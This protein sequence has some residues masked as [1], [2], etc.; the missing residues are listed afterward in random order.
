MS[1]SNVTVDFIFLGVQGP[2]LPAGTVPWLKVLSHGVELIKTSLEVG[3]QALADLEGHT[4]L[5]AADIK[6]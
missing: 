2:M 6:K 5:V 3:K 1:N 4:V